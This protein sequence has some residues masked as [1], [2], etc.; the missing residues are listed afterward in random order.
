M[1][2]SCLTTNDCE[3]IGEYPAKPAHERRIED[4]V[5]GDG[6]SSDPQ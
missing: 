1:D 4:L 6:E 3:R 2:T 5:P